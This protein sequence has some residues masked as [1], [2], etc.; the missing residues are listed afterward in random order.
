MSL[1]ICSHITILKRRKAYPFGIY[2][3]S[4]VSGHR[5]SSELGLCW[6]VRLAAD[7]WTITGMT[8]SEMKAA[9]WRA[10]LSNRLG[11]LEKLKELNGYSEGIITD[12]QSTISPNP[13]KEF[14]TTSISANVLFWLNCSCWVPS[15]KIKYSPHSQVLCPENGRYHYTLLCSTSICS[16]NHLVAT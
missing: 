16:K 15:W 11:L 8:L 2:V 5:V 7:L 13:Q 4:P 1:C 9:Q 10:L 6:Q 14:S 3:P 12:P